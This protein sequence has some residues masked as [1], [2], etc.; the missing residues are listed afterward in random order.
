MHLRFAGEMGRKGLALKSVAARSAEKREAGSL[1]VRVN[2]LV[3]RRTRVDSKW[4]GMTLSHGAQLA[5]DTTLVS[6]LRGDGR[7][8]LQCA[9]V[10]GAALMRARRR[11]ETPYWGER[12]CPVGGPWLR[13]GWSL[14]RRVPVF[15]CQVAKAKV[16]HEPPT[17]R[18]PVVDGATK[19]HSADGRVVKWWRKTG[20]PVRGRK[21]RLTGLA[22][23][24]HLLLSRKKNFQ[25]SGPVR[26]VLFLREI[27]HMCGN[28][29]SSLWP[30]YVL[31][32]PAVGWASHAPTQIQR[33]HVPSSKI[34]DLFANAET[35]HKRVDLA[36]TAVF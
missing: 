20:I 5:I 24:F 8:G 14:V 17:I 13:S 11:K 25:A 33:E 36:Q 7:P 30:D 32:L 23:C 15:L 35:W 3:A 18:A 31:G 27:S 10:D 21:G 34:Q 16:R 1:D 28:V 26:N 12:M 19:R 29:D 6:A 2:V 9:V 22:K 4:S